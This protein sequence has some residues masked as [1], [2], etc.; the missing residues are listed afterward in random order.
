M[1]DPISFK[2]FDISAAQ[3]FQFDKEITTIP[4]KKN[5][6]EFMVLNI[7]EEL[8]KKSK[9][10]VIELKNQEKIFEIEIAR[11]SDWE[12]FTVKSHLGNILKE[13]S[14]VQGNLKI[15]FRL[16]RIK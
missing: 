13:N 8:P 6:T 4:L 14:A 12:T 5:S 3:Y 7:K 11:V 10:P 16:Y 1:L 9:K 2:T 15:L